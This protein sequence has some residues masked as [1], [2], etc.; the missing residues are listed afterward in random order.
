[1]RGKF[2][3]SLERPE[4]FEPNQP[5]RV[6]F[7]MPDTYHSFRT[8][9]RIMVQGQSSWFPLVDRNPQ[10]FTDIYHAKQSDFQQAT[11]RVFRS[12]AMASKLKVLVLP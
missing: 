8:G 1:M 11:Q 4:P 3:N 12:A 10:K 7:T 5:T 6:R 2:R 9:H